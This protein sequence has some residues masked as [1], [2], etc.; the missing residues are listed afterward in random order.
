MGRAARKLRQDFSREDILAAARAL[1]ARE[2]AEKLTLSR[3][4]AEAEIAPRAMFAHFSSKNDLTLAIVADDLAAFAQTMRASKKVVA[5]EAF[6][7]PLAAAV[8]APPADASVEDRLAKLEARRV[9]A[10][11]ERRLRVFE[12]T[13]EALQTRQSAV[14]EAQARAI[15]TLERLGAELQQGAAAAEQGQSDGLRDMRALY[16]E[17]ANRIEAM[18]ATPPGEAFTEPFP[19]A[20]PTEPPAVSAPEPFEPTPVPEGY[21]GM[22]A[23][24]QAARAAAQR[25]AEAKKPDILARAKALFGRKHSRQTTVLAVVCL[26]LFAA[27]AGAALVLSEPHAKPAAVLR[28]AS[29][30][31]LGDVRVDSVRHRSPARLAANETGELDQLNRAAGE[32]DASAQYRLA[33]LFQRQ[34]DSASARTEALRWYERA[35]LQGHRKAMHNLAVAYAQ[36]WGVARNDEAAARWFSRAA[37]L[38]Y[39]DSQFN[40]A[41]LFE[42]GLGVPQSLF[43]AYKWYAIAA[44]NGD[45]EARERLEILD[46]QLPATQIAAARNEAARFAGS[47]TA[48]DPAQGR[49]K[50]GT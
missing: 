26:T 38:G 42:R 27:L 5:E 11:L 9:D 21:T 48:D 46:T 22:N 28:A 25:P 45:G 20:E 10:W 50:T 34:G 2:G 18:K 4:A 43:D 30:F 37:A 6:P 12:H 40:L 31:G 3:V 7:A 35:A 49:K 19:A 33:V 15:A 39:V 36:G 29:D 14:E 1:I 13:L 32:G 44:A 47:Q 17:L 41:V 24:R 16:V 8:A 23:A